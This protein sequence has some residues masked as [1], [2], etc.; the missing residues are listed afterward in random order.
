[1]DDILEVLELDVL[2]AIRIDN[3]IISQWE[4]NGIIKLHKC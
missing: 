4:N 2:G 3:Y 1:M